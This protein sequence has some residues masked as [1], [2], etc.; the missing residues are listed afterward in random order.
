[1]RAS[2]GRQLG[3]YTVGTVLAAAASAL[4]FFLYARLLAPEQLAVLILAQAI[5][6]MIRIL[7]TVGAPSGMFRYVAGP[8][9]DRQGRSV[10]SLVTTTLA[11]AVGV[12][13]VLGL[14]ALVIAPLVFSSLPGHDPVLLMALVALTAVASAPREIAELVLRADARAT[15]WSAY[16]VAGSSVVVACAALAVVLV[17]VTAEAI[18]SVQLFGLAAVSL[19]GLALIRRALH[20]GSIAPSAL[21]LVL[22]L[23]VPNS[24]SLVLDWTLRYIDRFI[25][26]AFVSAAEIGI[27]SFGSRLGLLVQQLGGAS[28]Q[29][30]WDP[31]SYRE[32]RQPEAPRRLGRSSTFLLVAVLGQAVLIG[33]GAAPLVAVVG[34]RPDY[35][36]GA[37]FAFPVGMAFW[38]GTA[39]YLLTTPLAL[40]FRP[41]LAIIALGAA[42]LTNLGLDLLLIPTYGIYGAAV[43]TIVSSAVG[44]VAGLLLGQRF[45]SIDFEPRKLALAAVAAI[46]AY[47]A[48]NAVSTPFDLATL[49]LRPL[50]AGIVYVALLVLLRVVPSPV[51]L[52]RRGTIAA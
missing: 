51:G 45:R 2:L 21:R 16:T 4:L 27:Y 6:T 32:H 39:R 29:A 3:W 44:A 33:A 37:A 14:L 47:V 41:E 10:A 38:L 43:A 31:Y 24:A 50:A 52:L 9:E 22:R 5:V 12:S 34:G 19:G 13:A 42:A 35:L 11:F 30:G 8:P 15:A 49:I 7:G 25:L 48:S 23:G 40:R 46:F 28:A 18:L 20:V 36:A 1:M 17:D 26:L